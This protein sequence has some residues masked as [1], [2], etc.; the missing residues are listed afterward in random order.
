METIT[1]YRLVVIEELPKEI[2]ENEKRVK[3]ENNVNLDFEPSEFNLKKP[4]IRDSETIASSAKGIN[5]L[6][7][8][9]IISKF[10]K[11]SLYIK[12]CDLNIN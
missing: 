9:L 1:H 12:L 7:S 4:K 8:S 10:S 11:L 5:G 6:G 3:I 2:E